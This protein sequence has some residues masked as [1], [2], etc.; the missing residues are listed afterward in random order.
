MSNYSAFFLNTSASVI[1]LELVEISHPNF[2]KVYYIVRNAISGVTVVLEDLSTH[3]FD[4]YPLS[5]KPTGTTNDLDQTIQVLVGDLGDII[6]LELDLVAVASGFSVKPTLKYRTYRSD[7]LSHVLLGPLVYQVDN[8]SFQEDGATLS[9][10]VPRL[11]LNQTGELYTLDRF[12]M[13]AG[14]L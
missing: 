3:T 14:F 2:S 1:Q 7:D 13:L 12:P 8:I 9:A 4:Y 6:P 5:I 10:S 11:N